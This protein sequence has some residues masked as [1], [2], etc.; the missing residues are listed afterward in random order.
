MCGGY[1]NVQNAGG[2]PVTWQKSGPESGGGDTSTW[3]IPPSRLDALTCSVRGPRKPA[4]TDAP[5]VTVTWHAGAFPEQAPTQISSAESGAGN[6]VTVTTVPIGYVNEQTSGANG[7]PLHCCG[8]M[9]GASSSSS[10][11]PFSRLPTETS[12]VAVSATAAVV[13]AGAELEKPSL[14]TSVTE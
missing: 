7:G 1:W 11:Q 13:V 14:T 8:G 4:P 9:P 2:P 3:P 6:A 5:C 12:S 10:P